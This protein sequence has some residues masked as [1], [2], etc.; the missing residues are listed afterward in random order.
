MHNEEIRIWVATPSHLLRKALT[1]FLRQFDKNVRVQESGERTLPQEAIIRFD[2][3]ILIVDGGFF[4]P[5]QTQSARSSLGFL[6]PETRICGLLHTGTDAAR[7]AL[8]DKALF[9]YDT[10][11]ELRRKIESLLAVPEPDE[12]RSASEDLT[13]REKEVLVELVK[14]YT[15]KEIGENLNLSVHTVISHRKNITR[16][17]DIKSSSGLTIYAIMNRLISIDEVKER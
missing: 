10:A 17:L 4:A 14:G 15:N 6:S 12:V 1:M 9:D 7:E 13:E 11:D 5:L 2:P 8:F 3:D 16:K